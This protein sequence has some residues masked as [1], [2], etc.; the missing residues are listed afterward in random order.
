MC[1]VPAVK[2]RGDRHVI[3]KILRKRG[4]LRGVY[5]KVR[6]RAH[7]AVRT[8]WFRVT[9]FFLDCRAY[10]AVRHGRDRYIFLSPEMG[11]LRLGSQCG[12]GQRACWTAAPPARVPGGPGRCPLGGSRSPHRQGL[13][14]RPWGFAEVAQAFVA[15]DGAGAVRAPPRRGRR[16]TGFGVPFARLPPRTPA[17]T[18][19]TAVSRDLQGG[20]TRGAPHAVAHSLW[21]RMRLPG[22]RRCGDQ[23]S[24]TVKTKCIFLKLKTQYAPNITPHYIICT[25]QTKSR[26]TEGHTLE[27]EFPPSG[28]TGMST[29]QHQEATETLAVVCDQKHI[30]VTSRL[31]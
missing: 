21:A 9:Y 17:H 31:L 19:R 10:G 29:E 23:K 7:R 22:S 27:R 15:S 28:Q 2:R 24:L 6:G 13:R 3:K 18:G 12:Q 1:C 30:S 14:G 20:A 11:H 5:G 26:R 25:I 8:A 4:H 16:P